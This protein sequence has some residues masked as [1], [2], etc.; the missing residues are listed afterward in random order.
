MKTMTTR[1]IASALV[2]S[3][4]VLPA[5]L[6]AK[7]RRGAELIV[8]RLDGSQVSGELIAVKRDSLLLLNNVGRDESIDLADIKTV[9]IVKKSRA[10]LLSGI[11]GAAGAATGVALGLNWMFEEWSNSQAKGALMGGAIFGAI[12]ALSGLVVGSALGLDPR[13]TVAGEREEV[14]AGYWDRLRAHSREG[15]LPD[16]LVSSEKLPEPAPRAG[17]VSPGASAPSRSRPPRGPRF[18]LSLSGVFRPGEAATVYRDGSFGF[19]EEAA[20][21]AGPYPATFSEW[22]STGGSAISLGPV[23]VAYEWADHWAAEIEFFI[24][25]SSS[26]TWAGRMGFT[27]SV[28]DKTYRSDFYHRYK[29]RFTS[30]LLGLAYRP[31][32]PS[33]NQRHVIEIGAA[34][35]PAWVRGET[36]PYTISNEFTL[37]V[38]QKVAISGRVQAGYDYCIVPALSLGFFA[39]Y[40]FMETNFSGIVSSG[41]TEFFEDIVS[42][43]PFGI[44]RLTEVALPSLP[45]NGSGAFFG[46]RLGVRI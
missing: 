16:I 42:P 13:F 4:L 45:V 41:T 34:I 35:G 8:T 30:F 37:P 44:V 17:A 31:L 20:P 46:L 32:S 22:S 19:P 9:Q 43:P 27:S 10:G 6:S 40:R 23:S 21:E 3:F 28:D 24:N 5:S 11:G 36:H 12:G 18:K 15:R 38:I 2:V 25:N 26:S 7:E 33:I 14:V 39:G 29:T 1:F